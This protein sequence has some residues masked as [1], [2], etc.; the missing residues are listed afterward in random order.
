MFPERGTRRDD[1]FPGLRVLGYRRRVSVTFTV[2]P[3]GVVIQGVFYGGQD[4]EA[5]LKEESE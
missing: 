5:L 1:V 4:F 2:E 3:E